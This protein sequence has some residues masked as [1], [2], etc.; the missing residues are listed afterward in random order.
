MKGQREQVVFIY[1]EMRERADGWG[2][3]EKQRRARGCLFPL[4]EG[5]GQET[6]KVLLKGAC[7]ISFSL[8]LQDP[9][10]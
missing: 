5:G 2:H 4:L 10:T 3:E 9:H 7:R 1:G 8:E 6:G